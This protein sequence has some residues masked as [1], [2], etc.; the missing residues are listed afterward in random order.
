MTSGAIGLGAARLGMS[1]KPKDTP[2]KQACAAI[3]QCELMNMYDKLFN[4]YNIIAAQVLLT[5][6]VLTDERKINVE[7]CIE[8][9]IAKGAIPIVNENDV[10]AIDE[11]EKSEKTIRSP[12]WLHVL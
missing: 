3:G 4:E 6:Y 12:R 9:I 7:N 5:K 8:T 2:T 1:S 10:V 11:L